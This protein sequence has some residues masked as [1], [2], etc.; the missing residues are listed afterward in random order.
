V[1]SPLSLIITAFAPSPDARRTLTP[2]LRTD[3]GETDLILF[4]LGRGQN[5]LGGSVLGQVYGELGDACPDLEEPARLKTFFALIQ[6]LNAEGKLLAYHDR[7]DGGL[8]ATVCE[9]AFAGRCGVNLD[10]DELRYHRIHDDIMLDVEDAPD[11]HEPYTSRLFGILFNEELGAVVQV[12]RSDTRAVMDAILEADLRDEFY[13]IGSTNRKDRI[14]VLRE[15][16]AVFDES[17]ADLLEAWSETSY[18]MQALRDNPDCAREEFK[19]L[20]AKKNPG[21]ARQTHFRPE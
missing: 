11:P 17:R 7:A 16:T 4:D 8:F 6:K 19:G 9:M 3:A 14:R 21:P 15:G 18:R 13:I 12:R 1:V 10:V 20:T 2:Q 5:R